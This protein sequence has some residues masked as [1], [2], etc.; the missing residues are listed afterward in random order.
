[1]HG[2]GDDAGDS[3]RVSS[4]ERHVGWQSI[5]LSRPRP[6]LIDREIAR[7]IRKMPEMTAT[8]L[9]AA[10]SSVHSVILM[11]VVRRFKRLLLQISLVLRSQTRISAVSIGI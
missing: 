1:M 5:E 9:L 2:D 3:L 10:L 11:V 4:I 6:L 7:F 8:I